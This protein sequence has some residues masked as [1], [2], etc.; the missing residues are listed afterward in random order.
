MAHTPADTP[1]PSND[2]LPL[3]L[4]IWTEV[5]DQL[6]APDIAHLAEASRS[7]LQLVSC[8]SVKREWR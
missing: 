4:D 3:D 6:D 2:D 8:A 5:L 7:T 1:T